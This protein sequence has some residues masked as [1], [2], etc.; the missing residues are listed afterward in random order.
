MRPLAEL[1]DAMVY[2]GGGKVAVRAEGGRRAADDDGA[3]C[4]A[5]LLEDR[6]VRGGT[7][8]EGACGAD[9][10]YAA[11]CHS[12]HAFAQRDADCGAATRCAMPALNALPKHAMPSA[13]TAGL[14]LLFLLLPLPALDKSMKETTKSAAQAFL[15]QVADQAREGRREQERTRESK[16]KRARARE[17]ARKRER[18]SASGAEHVRC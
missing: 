11:R 5:E 14:L 1:R 7:E 16:S 8:R 2:G 6:D 10:R 4:G 17:R 18:A 13:E 3:V 15:L 12:A 9:Q